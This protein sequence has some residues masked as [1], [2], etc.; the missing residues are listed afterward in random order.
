MR[1]GAS[2]SGVTTVRAFVA[3]GSNLGDRLANL[4]R[5]VALLSGRKGVAV[6]VTS[7]VYET[8]PVGPPQPSYLNAVVEVATSLGPRE[9]LQT[10]LSVEEEMGRVRGEHWG[11]RVIDLDVLTFG[12]ETIDQ[13]DLTVPH[14]RMF[15]RAFVLAPLLELL[16][17]PSLPGGRSIAALRL[18]A[19]G[20]GEVRPFAHAISASFDT[21]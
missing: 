16:A 11:P 14:P 5:A 20:S 7:R 1:H 8:E 19:A 17:G 2:P 15:E 18:G 12:E 10:C 9:L 13:P 4:R 6:V 21:A 3:L